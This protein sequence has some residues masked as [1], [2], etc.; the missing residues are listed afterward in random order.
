MQ[1]EKHQRKT[2]GFYALM[3]G[4]VTSG[5]ERQD[6]VRV[7][8]AYIYDSRTTACFHIAAITDILRPFPTELTSLK[9]SITIIR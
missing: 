3:A 9:E 5:D 4:C 8:A 6:R 1:L 2:V 7:S